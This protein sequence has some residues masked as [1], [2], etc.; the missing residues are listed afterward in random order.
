MAA[1]H[2][3]EALVAA[4]S[5]DWL[6]ESVLLNSVARDQ[7]TGACSML[8]RRFAKLTGDMCHRMIMALPPQK[9]ICFTCSGGNVRA[10]VGV[11]MDPVWAKKTSELSKLM[12]ARRHI[13]A[14]E[15]ILSTGEMAVAAELAFAAVRSL[16]VIQEP[17]FTVKGNAFVIQGTV[18]KAWASELDRMRSTVGLEDFI[19]FGEAGVIRVRIRVPLA[20]L[21]EQALSRLTHVNEARSHKRMRHSVGSADS[22]SDENSDAPSAQ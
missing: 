12:N 16:R 9:D 7:D 5:G 19:L 8:L 13:P 2:G 14:L 1:V 10:E 3:V 18:R 6:R 22:G 11:E 17:A 20:H 21:R 15:G 4:L